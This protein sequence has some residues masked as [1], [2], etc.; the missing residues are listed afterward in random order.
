[1]KKR[2]LGDVSSWYEF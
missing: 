1:M 2:V